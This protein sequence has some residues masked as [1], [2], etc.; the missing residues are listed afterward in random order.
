MGVVA[1]QTG[2]AFEFG[3][4]GI[5]GVDTCGAAN[6]LHLQAIAN[7]DPGWADLHAA[8]AVDAITCI[9]VLGFAGWVAAMRVVTDHHGVI[10]REGRLDTAVGAHDDAELLTE[11]GKA[12][13]EYDGQKSDHAK[14]HGMFSRAFLHVEVEVFQGDEVGN[15]DVGDQGG[16]EQEQAVF[17]DAFGCFLRRFGGGVEFSPGLGVTFNKPFNPAENVVEENGVGAGPTAP[18][19]S[20]Q[21]G[22]KKQGEAQAGDKEKEQPEVLDGQRDAEHVETAL[23]GIE[24]EGGVPVDRNP[25]ERSVKNNQGIADNSPP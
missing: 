25:G 24:K 4:D 6:A 8:S 16:T 21:S 13:V 7:I 9:G 14:R 19:P 10:I 12:E 23:G 11:P 1:D 18:D 20:E 22:D 17:D 2:G 5:T 3:H 15:K